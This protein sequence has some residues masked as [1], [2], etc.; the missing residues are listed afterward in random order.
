MKIVDGV[1]QT[2]H[3][4]EQAGK[5]IQNHASLPF[6]HLIASDYQYA[7]HEKGNDYSLIPYFTI[8]SSIIPS[9]MTRRSVSVMVLSML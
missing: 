4:R 3:S 2:T 6:I 9:G 7:I 5:Q 1:A 8:R